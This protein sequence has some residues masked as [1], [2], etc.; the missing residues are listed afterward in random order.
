MRTFLF[1]FILQLAY[2]KCYAQFFTISADSLHQQ[3]RAAIQLPNDTLIREKKGIIPIMRNNTDSIQTTKRETKL[4]PDTRGCEI[5]I[6]KDLPLFVVVRNNPLFDLIQKRVTVCLPLDYL[7]QN[8]GYGYRKDPVYRCQKFHDGIDLS[9]RFGNVYAMLPGIVK[10]VHRG[11]RGYGNY[12]VLQHGNIECLY[13]HLSMIL[14]NENDEIQAGDIV[15]ISGNT[16]K[17]TGPHLHIRLRKDGKSINPKPFITYLNDYIDDLQDRIVSLKFGGKPDEELN[18]SNLAKALEAYHVKYPKIVIA[19]ALLETGYFTS[20]VCWECKNLFG[21]R[22]P[23]DG[24]YY[25][26]DHWEESVKAYRDYVQYKY[27]GGNYL[28]FLDRIGYAEDKTYTMKVLQ[29]A[30]RL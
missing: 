3:V 17:S 10:E 27:K 22:R 13:G 20:R 18:I 1:I 24:S 19:Q 21:L 5:S 12:V 7:K 16:G 15:A 4:F 11:N 26:F 14:V 9:C 28:Q 25:K 8:S 30:K 29:I 2:I 23:S 6:E